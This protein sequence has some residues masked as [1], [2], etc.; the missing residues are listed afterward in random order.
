M[1]HPSKFSDFS[2][3]L[4]A[5]PSDGFELVFSLW[6]EEKMVMGRSYGREHFIATMTA[7][8]LMYD[9]GYQLLIDSSKVDIDVL[10]SKMTGSKK[11]FF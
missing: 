4:H 11:D 3:A 5:L 9:S 6:G 2:I 1:R 7:D 8:G 10:L